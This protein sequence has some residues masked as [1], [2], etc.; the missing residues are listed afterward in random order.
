MGPAVVAGGA[1]LLGGFLANRGRKQEAQKDR[2]FQE[3]M[4]STSWQRGKADMMAA[5]INP[6]LAYAKGGA[7]SP[8]GAMAGQEDIISGAVSSA[9]QARRL[10]KE[11][12]VLD[13][14]RLNIGKDTML[15][16]AQEGE[17][18]LRSNL[19][20]EQEEGA[21]IANAQARLLTPWLQ[22]QNRAA[23]RYGDQAAMM[24]LM[25]NSGGS[26]LATLA[27]GGIVGSLFRGRSLAKKR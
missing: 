6:A 11:L 21:K 16:Q 9:Q 1:A 17:A 13:E 5:G 27:T 20:A 23:M 12:K 8:G 26:Q 24:Q 19:Y 14:Q 2:D 18:I 4:S 15:K 25:L 10:K 22:S 7:S 3:R